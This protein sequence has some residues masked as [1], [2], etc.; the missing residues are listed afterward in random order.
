[1]AVEAGATLSWWRCVGTDARVIGL[2]QCGTSGNGPGP[3]EH[4]G[5]T[6]ERIEREVGELLYTAT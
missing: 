3:F 6:A 1:M 2:D 4:F 5:F